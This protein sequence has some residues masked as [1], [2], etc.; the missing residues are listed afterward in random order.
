MFVRVLARPRPRPAFVAGPLVSVSLH[1]AVVVAVVATDGS[2]VPGARGDVHGAGVGGERT[3]WVGLA[4]VAGDANGSSP[5]GAPPFAYVVPGRGPLHMLPA[6]TV[7]RRGAPSSAAR[8][9]GREAFRAGRPMRRL[10][11][12]PALTSIEEIADDAMLLVSG[13]AASSPDLAARASRPEDFKRGGDGL[14]D[15]AFSPT[16]SLAYSDS[17][18]DE[19]PIPMMTNPRPTYPVTLQRANV[20]GSVVVE[21]RIDS[22][23]VVDP[24]TLRVVQSSNALFVQA[25][26]QVLPLMHFV[27]AQM[28][29]RSVSVTVR[30]PFLFRIKPWE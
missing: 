18:V 27:P 12:L 28:G 4:P 2:L 23:G 9:T 10:P 24:T 15:R 21:F 14:W 1:A 13:L 8:G 25:I 26:R 22:T 3:H 19:L 6:G 16:M 20:A 17:R 5:T 29:A 11:T 30:Q 7:V